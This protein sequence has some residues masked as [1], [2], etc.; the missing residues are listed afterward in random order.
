MQLC[1]GHVAIVTT[2]A[3]VATSSTP[4]PVAVDTPTRIENGA[5]GTRTHDQGHRKPFAMPYSDMETHSET[6]LSSPSRAAGCPVSYD[7]GHVRRSINK[8]PAVEQRPHDRRPCRPET[9]RAFPLTARQRDHRFRNTQ[10]ASLPPLNSILGAERPS[11]SAPE[12]ANCNTRVT[13][14]LAD[15][16]N[17]FRQ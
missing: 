4:L 6:Q 5:G 12:T 7:R 2:L 16:A 1:H 3:A 8:Q 9:A 14:S 13:P 11:N 17:D 10:R 15:G